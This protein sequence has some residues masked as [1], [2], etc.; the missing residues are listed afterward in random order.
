M[1]YLD[2]LPDRDVR[3]LKQKHEMRPSKLEKQDT[4]QSRKATD[5]DENDKVKARSKGQ[6]E[7][8]EIR[9]VEGP[10]KV[11]W[12]SVRCPRRAVHV[13]HMLGGNGTR[14][15]GKS[16]LAKHKQHLCQRC[17]SDIHAHVLRRFGQVEPIWTDEYE[18]VK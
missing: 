2:S 11:Y 12:V 13:H 17:H 6:C 3:P 1:G 5:E 4:R 10:R 14:A 18:R 16:A 8:H 7:V 9:R 15:R